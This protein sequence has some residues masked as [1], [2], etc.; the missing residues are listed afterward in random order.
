MVSKGNLYERLSNKFRPCLIYKRL[1]C[2]EVSVE[3]TYFNFYIN[4]IYSP[5]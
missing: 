5:T 2:Y 1:V 4:L 3:F